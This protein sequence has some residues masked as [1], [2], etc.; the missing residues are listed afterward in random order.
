MTTPRLPRSQGRGPRVAMLVYNDAH[1]DTRVL[2]EAASLRAAGATVR[3]F[4]VARPRAGYGPGLEEVAD[5]VDINRL[6]EFGLGGITARMRGDRPAASGPDPAPPADDASGPVAQADQPNSPA[7]S[8]PEP[9]RG[10]RA[11]RRGLA[12]AGAL[13]GRAG[14]DAA[15]RAYRTVSLS[16]YW[17]RAARAVLAWSPD[18]VHAN[19]ANTLAPALWVVDRCGAR[20]VYDSH[21]LWRH[22]N[23]RPDRPVAPRVEAAIETR[24]IERAD[25]VLTVSPSIVE[26]LDEHY[27]LSAPPVLVRNI[28]VAGPPPDPARGRLRELAGLGAEARVIAY[29]GR[30]T[31]SRGLEETVAALAEL[32]EDVHLVMLGYG[33][34]D[35]LAALDEDVRRAGVADRVHRVGP[36]A[37]HEVAQALADADLSVVHVRPTC[38]SY[39]FALPNKLFESIRAGLPV[40]AADLPDI[41]AVVEE[42]GVG[43]VFDGED[44]GALAQTIA[45]ILA[46]PGRYRAAARAAAPSLTWERESEALLG[47]YR[48]A[49][50]GDRA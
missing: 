27:R 15:M 37:P 33:E 13:V 32:P 50:M 9:S 18:V 7:G 12:A 44:P 14:A 10:P 16:A 5:G 19:D 41:R 29:G 31:T 30:L 4:A 43:E 38:L 6:R 40:A 28:P 39:R 23:V 11:V 21:E 47:A 49:L 17:L 42:L 2:K 22:R 35:Y 45:T 48:Q 46:D 3:I 24:G 25:A 34:P 8:P 36:V 26:W 1:N 20:L